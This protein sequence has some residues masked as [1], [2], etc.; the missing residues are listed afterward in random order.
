MPLMAV[1]LSPAE[2]HRPG[3]PV[4]TGHKLPHHKPG[5][6]SPPGARRRSLPAF[7]AVG[8]L[9]LIGQQ[10]APVA[11]GAWPRYGDQGL[12]REMA[13]TLPRG[14]MAPGRTS[15]ARRSSAAP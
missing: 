8:R 5:M 6:P 9:P 15:H 11:M 14:Y 13:A 2:G 1:R 4:S 10:P 12:S 3:L 7:T